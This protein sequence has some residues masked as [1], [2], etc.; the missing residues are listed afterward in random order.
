MIW[1][2]RPAQLAMQATLLLALEPEGTCRRVR[3]IAAALGVSATYLSKV[4]QDL[5]RAGL[6]RAVRGP[7]GG[8]QLARAA[9]YMYLWDVLSAIQPMDELK[10]CFLGLDRC[11]ERNPCPLDKAWASMRAEIL[12]ALQTKNL[13]EFASEAQTNGILAGNQGASFRA[14]SAGH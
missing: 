13:H 7:G 12:G 1:Y 2:R 5:T 8:V 6:V 4:F 11:S 10:G 14:E 9:R 3:E